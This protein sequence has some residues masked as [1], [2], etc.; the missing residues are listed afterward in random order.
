M[1][2]L[3]CNKEH[4]YNLTYFSFFFFFFA[5]PLGYFLLKCGI[6]IKLSI[7]QIGILQSLKIIIWHK[8]LSWCRK[9]SFGINICS[10]LIGSLPNLLERVLTHSVFNCRS[11]FEDL[12]HCTLEMVVELRRKHGT[13]TLQ[14]LL[15]DPLKATY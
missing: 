6:F 9:S 15:W 3:M 5:A 12:L 14:L 8:K 1:L 4:E 2:F 7:N 10:Y 13:Y 11:W